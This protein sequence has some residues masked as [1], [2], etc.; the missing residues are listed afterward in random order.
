MSEIF[1]FGWLGKDNSSLNLQEIERGSST[2][3][4]REARTLLGNPDNLYILSQSTSR[5][6]VS[7]NTMDRMLSG[8]TSDPDFRFVL[9]KDDSGNEQ[10]KYEGSIWVLDASF[11]DWIYQNI[12]PSKA[13][14]YNYYFVD[15][16][17]IKKYNGGIII[18][19]Q[20]PFNSKQEFEDKL[21]EI[22]N[23]NNRNTA[24]GGNP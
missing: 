14:G 15:E 22:A 23:P 17:D 20:Y 18:K 13:R 1:D 7:E 5:W 11:R 21:K 8:N 10:N 9:I 16:E 19:Q 3:L 2:R 4:G 24:S 12:E 6:S